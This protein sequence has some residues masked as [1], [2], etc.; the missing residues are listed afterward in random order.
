MGNNA[1]KRPSDTVDLLSLIGNAIEQLGQ[2]IELFER[3][4][5]RVGLQR[6]SNVIHDIDTYLVHIEEDPL[7]RIAGVDSVRLADGLHH[8]QQDLSAVIRQLDASAT[9]DASATV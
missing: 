4:D 9:P 3:A 2:C 7:V 8:V 1:V 6:L 5:S